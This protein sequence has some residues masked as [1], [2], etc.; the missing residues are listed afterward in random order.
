[1]QYRRG[2]VLTIWQTDTERQH[3][4]DHQQCHNQTEG[5]GEAAEHRS[6]QRAKHATDAEAEI[7]QAVVFGQV[8]EAEEIADQ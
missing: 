2:Q 8:V 4:R 1:M 5:H 7:D 3:Q 6:H